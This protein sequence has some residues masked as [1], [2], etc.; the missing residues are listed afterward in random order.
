LSAAL[1]QIYPLIRSQ[2]AE[3]AAM[4]KQKLT[5]ANNAYIASLKEFSSFQEELMQ[6]SIQD[7]SSAY[8]KPWSA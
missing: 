5:P 3:A 1:E 4:V 6:K 7:A 2:S 8:R